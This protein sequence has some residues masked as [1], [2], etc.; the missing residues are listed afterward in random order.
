MIEKY[1]RKDKEL[2]AK[3]KRSNYRTKYFCGGV[4][5]PQQIFR[6][7]KTIMPNFF[8]KYVINCYHMYLIHTVMDR[9]EATNS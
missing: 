2:L 3:I 8:Q 5:V 9:T 6:N 1:Q 7:D 4:K